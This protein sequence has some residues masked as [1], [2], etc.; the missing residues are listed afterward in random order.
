MASAFTTRIWE[1]FLSLSYKATSQPGARGST[2]YTASYLHLPQSERYQKRNGKPDK[3]CIERKERLSCVDA[4][5]ELIQRDSPFSSRELLFKHEPLD[6]SQPA[7]S[8]V[9]VSRRLSAEGYIQCFMRRTTVHANYACLSYAWGKPKQRHVILINGRKF[10]VQQNLFDFLDTIRGRSRSRHE[11]YWIDA[12]CIDQSNAA[13]RNHQVAQM[14]MIYSK[15]VGVYAWL[16]PL[17]PTSGN[18]CY[19]FKYL[20]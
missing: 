3:S 4:V 11:D 10:H 15:A 16:G 6:H 13:E 20:I 5:S 9:T 8:L 7:I 2:S 18:H 12:L 17:G 14:G 1:L 19:M